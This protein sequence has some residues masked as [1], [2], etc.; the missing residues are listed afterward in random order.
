MKRRVQLLPLAES[1]S[2]RRQAWDAAAGP[3]ASSGPERSWAG[4]WVQQWR[5]VRR[6]LTR[7][8]SPWLDP[9]PSCPV[10]QALLRIR[11]LELEQVT[12]RQWERQSRKVK[13]Q[14]Q[15]SRRV[16]REVP[17]LRMGKPGPM[18]PLRKVRPLVLAKRLRRVNLLQQQT[19]RQTESVKPLRT[20]EQELDLM[21]L[22]R[23]E[24]P[25]SM[26]KRLRKA[27]PEP[28]PQT[29]NPQEQV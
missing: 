16:Q 12:Q 28:K 29:E 24:R 17:S 25:L 2:A 10:W 21:L 11:G 22:P 18:L 3:K 4:C 7:K 19:V 27:R 5:L 8:D 23:T 26:A 15:T 1:T 20:G 14:H 9:G 13:P 6:V